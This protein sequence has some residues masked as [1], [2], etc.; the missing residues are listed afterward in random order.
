MNEEKHV[1]IN[2]FILRNIYY[3]GKKSTAELD[4]DAYK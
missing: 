3:T 4:K 2:K 1:R